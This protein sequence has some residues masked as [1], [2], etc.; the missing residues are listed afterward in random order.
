MS[1]DPNLL[2]VRVSVFDGPASEEAWSQVAPVL[3]E[4]ALLGDKG[5]LP[6]CG[7]LLLASADWCRA[8]TQP[9]PERV[10]AEFRSRLGYDV[11]LIGG[12]SP[13]LFASVPRLGEPDR[14]YFLERGVVAITLFS[15][16]MWFSVRSLRE[17]FTLSEPQRRSQLST[18]AEELYRDR[19]RHM[20]LGSSVQLDLVAF[21]PGP[22]TSK[23]GQREL[24][25]EELF[26]EIQD[27][28]KNLLRMF[29]GSAADEVDS[30]RGYQF[31][32]DECLTSGL[33][34]AM[35]ENDL[36]P[37]V[38]MGHGFLVREDKE[39]TSVTAQ[40][41]PNP[42][43]SLYVTELGGRAAADV[44]NEWASQQ[45]FERGRPVF[46]IGGNP[47]C[48]I[49]TTSTAP[50]FGPGPV[51]FDRRL[52]LGAP[53][54]RLS[55]DDEELK[56]GAVGV[57]K[58]AR[59]R[60]NAPDHL[61]RLLFSVC[62]AGRFQHGDQF[63]EGLWRDNMTAM[64]G[65]A[66]GVPLVCILCSGE[67]AEDH[68]RRPR[69]DSFSLWV[70][71]FT[72]SKGRRSET[73]ILQNRL[74]EASASLLRCNTPREVMDAALEG[75][76][77]AGAEGGQ[78]CLADTFVDAI[79]GL[80]V[81]HARNREG[82]MQRWDLVIRE[83]K[84]RLPSGTQRL[85]LPEPL[86][87]NM[88]YFAA[89]PDAV[90]L[91]EL[92]DEDELLEIVASE[93]CSL[94]IPDSTDPVYHC[95]QARV[96]LGHTE[97]QFVAPLIGSGDAL[98]GTLQV[99]FGLRHPMDRER[100]GLWTG[101]GQK[102]AAALERA[103]ELEERRRIEE[104]TLV[105]NEIL[106]KPTPVG[107]PEELL[108]RLTTEIRKQLEATYVHLR[109]R[110]MFQG[111]A[112]YRLAA[113]VGPLAGIH[114]KVRQ[115]IGED[116]GAVGVALRHKTTF[117]NR[118]GDTTRFY[119]DAQRA[120]D[121]VDDEMRRLWIAE[122]GRLKS[123]GV[124]ELRNREDFLGVL[125]ID[126]EDE[127]FFTERRKRIAELV[128]QKVAIILAKFRAEENQT[129]VVQLG[130]Y[131]AKNIHDITQP[132]GRIQRS[133]DVLRLMGLSEDMADVLKSLESAKNEVF[134]KLRDA[135][136]GMELGEA[137]TPLGELLRPV[138]ARGIRIDWRPTELTGRVLRTNI[139]LRSAIER[140]AE[141]ALEAVERP[142]E[143]SIV[144]SELLPTSV[145]IQIENGGARISQEDIQ[146]MYLP[147]HSTKRADHL[148]LGIPLADFGIRLAGGDLD[149]EPRT[150]G[151]LQ[152]RVCLPLASDDA[153]TNG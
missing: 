103:L 36:Q 25:D 82:S 136:Q 81:G 31:A 14:R 102:V 109:L 115:Y 30:T 32:N 98:V 50:P 21:M 138:E 137:L 56:R 119:V 47:N 151:G 96:R 16:E 44:L 153:R 40:D 11:Q 111:I 149:L 132:L 134:K 129:A 35:M 92:T 34:I 17:P 110:E 19:G 49:A 147:G 93:R 4:Q 114:F 38:V 3:A 64:A 15:R 59:A 70:S 42:E 79:L 23:D 22:L 80:H 68:R 118:L 122:S 144:V 150:E 130:L 55:G 51:R 88:M 54:F 43:P 66:H 107:D 60:I 28:F 71:C 5:D 133:I 63:E 69:A 105:W 100:M 145:C 9:L 124:F 46:G 45:P 86:L 12:S 101:F 62:C 112:R 85:R 148:G 1:E 106:Q 74:L 58:K 99:G 27:A 72:S 41:S 120:D 127:Y 8:E 113:A 10:R 135:A 33:A 152:A 91:R 123:S 26:V 117:T 90:V 146:N 18:L 20:G 121:T 128:A 141:N 7:I 143:V 24:R 57:L 104:I 67:F 53:L 89:L 142:Q 87:A 39:W 116:E 140:L 73:R 95:N 139:W 108:L 29:G 131:A 75:A 52:P 84:V 2:Q 94:F 77:S 61:V 65:E 126:S 13:R 6:V 78:I 48:Q 83:T 76:V 37:S 97:A 125:V